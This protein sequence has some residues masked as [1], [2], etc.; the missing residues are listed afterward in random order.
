MK[1][2]SWIYWNPSNTLFRLLDSGIILSIE[3]DSRIRSI[4]LPPIRT[5][6]A[7][8]IFTEGRRMSKRLS[9]KCTSRSLSL[10]EVISIWVKCFYSQLNREWSLT[11]MQGGY[12]WTLF[13]LGKVAQEEFLLTT[14]PWHLCISSSRTRGIIGI[15][16]EFA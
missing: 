9:Y 16:L 4:S 1:S 10:L 7:M 6:K 3:E 2:I 11:N 12:S 5:H 15:L 8:F 14:F 13:Q